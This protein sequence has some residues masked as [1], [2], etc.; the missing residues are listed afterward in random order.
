MNILV[1]NWRDIKN[2]EMGGAEVHLQEIF[3]RIAAK[4]HSV[5]L[6][7]HNFENA[8][9]EETVEGIKIKRIGNKFLFNRQFKKYYLQELKNKDYD[10]IVDDISKIPLNTP[11][12]I[13][14]P[15]VGIIHHIHGNSLY[16]EIPFPMAYYIISKEKQIPKY[17]SGTPLFT[18]SKSTSDELIAN[19]FPED[20][21]DSLYN[22][23]DHKLFENIKPEKSI[24]P[25]LTY[26]GRIKK[27]KN[28]DKVINAMPKLIKKIP[29]L[30]L[31]IGGKGDYSDS[32]KE[33]VKKLN[34]EKYVEF[35][36]FL[37]EEEKAKLLGR[38][39]IFVTMAEKEGWGITVIEANAMRTPAI[40]SNVPGLRDSIKNGETGYL[41]PLGDSEKLAERIENLIVNRKE[42]EK[43]S[44][45]A[46]NWAK[47]FTWEK[48][49]NHFLEQ[50]KVWYPEIKK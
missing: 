7:A 2:P 14:K 18:V 24:T 31:I 45:N 22:G 35:T 33:L 50:I 44:E 27:Y 3:K 46:M 4:G 9:S 15:I 41:V 5:T 21:L 25:L 10:L 6:I 36:G 17:Y 11:T 16:K 40:G 20:K 32:L 13:E 26:I 8:P 42:L 23:I 39:W 30:K 12:Y 37:S 49:A 38:A 28:I 1:I 34:L 19:G 43:T 47:T 48:S 29:D